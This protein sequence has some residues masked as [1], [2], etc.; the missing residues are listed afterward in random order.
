[1]QR[2]WKNPKRN[3]FTW[4]SYISHAR[5]SKSFIFLTWS[6]THI[7]MIFYFKSNTLLTMWCS[8]DLCGCPLHKFVK[9]FHWF[10]SHFSA[11]LS[12]ANCSWRWSLTF[13]YVFSVSHRWWNRWKFVLCIWLGASQKFVHFKFHKS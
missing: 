3:L 7:Y 12:S 6:H 8:K 10:A 2:C 4:P 5:E 11:L 9:I 13:A 1:M